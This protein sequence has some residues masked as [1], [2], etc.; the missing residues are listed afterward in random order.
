MKTEIYIAQSEQTKISKTLFNSLRFTKT[1]AFK[2]TGAFHQWFSIAQWIKKEF[3]SIQDNEKRNALLR[4]RT[5]EEI[6]NSRETSGCGDVALIFLSI[7]RELGFPGIYV[8]T[9]RR[10]WLNLGGE[11]IEGHVFIEIY[12]NNYWWIFDPDMGAI[13]GWYNQYIIIAKG[14]DAWD[15]GIKNFIDLKNRLTEFRQNFKPPASP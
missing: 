15:I 13:I 10:K 7:I 9:V 1:E 6:I 3:S 8:E 11:I 2:K 4:K 5:S 12:F 14:K